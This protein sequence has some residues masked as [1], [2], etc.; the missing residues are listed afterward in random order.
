MSF[1][2]R[3]DRPTGRRKTGRRGLDPA[4]RLD[5]DQDLKGL[6]VATFLQGSVRRSTAIRPSGD[7]RPDVDIVVVTNIDYENTTPEQAMKK[8]V[9]SLIA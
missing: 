9:P 7:K 4:G 1:L 3:S 5:A 8:F 6:V 2:R